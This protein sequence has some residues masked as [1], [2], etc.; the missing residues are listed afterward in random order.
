VS[1][2]DDG[3]AAFPLPKQVFG[4]NACLQYSDTGMTLRDYFAAAALTGIVSSMYCTPNVTF[5]EVAGRAYAQ[6]D[7][8]LEAR[9]EASHE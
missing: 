9:K 3:G 4:E 1:K 8:M 2:I 7:A 6:A 5:D